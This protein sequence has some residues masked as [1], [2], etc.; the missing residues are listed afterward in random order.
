MNKKKRLLK[1]SMLLWGFVTAF[2]LSIIIGNYGSLSGEGR[3]Y[4]DESMNKTGVY[5]ASYTANGKTTTE[6]CYLKN[7]KVQYNYTGFASNSNGW[8]YVEKGKVTF[9]K[10]DVIK[11]TVK[12][13]SGWWFV[14]GSKVQFVNSVEKNSSGWW[15]IKNGKV[16]FSFTGFAEKIASYGDANVSFYYKESKGN[17]IVSRYSTWWYVKN[18]K[19]DFSK[20]DV[21]KGIVNGYSGWWYVKNG[22]VQLGEYT[23]A[24]NSSG[25]WAIR[26]GKVNFNYTGYAKNKNGCFYCENGKVVFSKKTQALSSKS[27]IGDVVTFGSYEQDAVISNGKEKIDWIVLDKASDGSVLLIS[28]FGLDQQFYSDDNNQYTKWE[29]SHI[30]KWLN[31]SFLNTAFN[32]SEKAKIKTTL[33]KNGINPEVEPTNNDGGNDTK[34]KLFLLSKDE[35]KS[36]FKDNEGRMCR[37]TE[38]AKNN[39]SYSAKISSSN[40]HEYMDGTVQKSNDLVDGNCLWLLRTPATLRLTY[41]VNVYG[42]L[43]IFIYG[44][45]P[46]GEIVAA[47]R[48]SRY[49]IYTIRPA[50]WVKP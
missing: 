30:R 21:M 46:N 38:Y 42:E 43:T 29:N 22:K 14:K 48:D 5:K 36:Y 45:R 25:W 33:V 10:N 19:V 13:Q 3:V 37:A 40:Y 16:D 7:G 1:I 6:W 15:C 2:C 39:G 44:I 50:M 23:V 17:T 12:G 34:D 11:G 32:S 9:K 28:K 27:K 41:N 35:A 8:W 24:K 49:D 47:S 18:G 20:T 31:N 4:A 26:D